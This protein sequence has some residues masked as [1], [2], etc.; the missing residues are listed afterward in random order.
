VASDVVWITRAVLL[1]LNALGV[2]SDHPPGG[3]P[4]IETP[5]PWI[6][7]MNSASV[8]VAPAGLASVKVVPTPVVVVRL[9][10]S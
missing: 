4:G 2:P 7:K 3:T 10:T 1:V 6:T 8:D 5:A 9:R